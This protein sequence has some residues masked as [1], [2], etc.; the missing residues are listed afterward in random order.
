ME[1][2]GWLAGVVRRVVRAVRSVVARLWR[3]RRDEPKPAHRP[4]RRAFPVWLKLAYTGFVAVLVPFYVA[5]YGPSNFLWFSDIALLTTV[6]ALWRESRLLASTM[7]VGTLAFELVWNFGY[8]VR[9]LTGTDPTG[10]AE[11]MFDP[12][13][14]LFLRGLSLFH[15]VLPPLLLFMLHRLGYDGRALPLQTGLA[16]VVLPASYA[17][18]DR[19]ANINWVFGP[20]GVQTWMPEPLYLLALMAGF[21]LLVYLPTHL[22]LGRLF[23]R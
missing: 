22:V 4:P 21:P 1:P 12:T 7:A 8:I 10:I 18:S 15:V 23:G 20:G 16:W 11:Y 3:A 19:E 6:V 2:F 9:L 14:G 17:V 13:V 5:N